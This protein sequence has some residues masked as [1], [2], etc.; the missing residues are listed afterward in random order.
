ME[1]RKMSCKFKSNIW[2]HFESKLTFGY[3]N[4]AIDRE[5]V[6]SETGPFITLLQAI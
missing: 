4:K 6:D 5:F 1:C 3:V 2:M